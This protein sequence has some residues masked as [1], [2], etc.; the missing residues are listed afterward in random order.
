VIKDAEQRDSCIASVAATKGDVRICNSIIDADDKARCINGIGITS[1]LFDKGNPFQNISVCNTDAMRASAEG[2]DLCIVMV[3]GS[4]INP[5]LC[6]QVQDENSRDTCFL[7]FSMTGDTSV[8]T[9]IGDDYMRDGC[10]KIIAEGTKDL[11]LCD[12]IQ[13]EEMAAECRNITKHG[14]T[15]GIV[16]TPEQLAEAANK[17]RRTGGSFNPAGSVCT[18]P[19]FLLASEVVAGHAEA[20]DGGG[21]IDTDHCYQAIAVNLGDASLCQNINRPAPRSKCYLLIAEKAGS[22][23]FCNLMPENLESMDSY[24]QI[25]CIQSVAIKTGDSRLCDEMGIRN[26]SRMFTGEVSRQACYQRVASGSS[27]GGSL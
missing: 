11:E 15:S 5:D 16:T 21:G 17:N 18:S 27:T 9:R 8:C 7:V 23:V 2:R 26:L 25:E 1:A 22:T 10:F 12:E 3:A 20:G 24:A 19:A 4:T 13:N 6:E 14:G